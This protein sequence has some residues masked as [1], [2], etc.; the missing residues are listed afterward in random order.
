MASA[1]FYPPQRVAAALN[2]YRDN[3]DSAAL[4][5]DASWSALPD[6]GWREALSRASSA[7]RRACSQAL[8]RAAGVREPPFGAFATPAVLGTGGA[9]VQPAPGGPKPNL[10]LLDALPVG[11]ALAVLRMRS[12]S[13]RRVEVRRLIDKQTRSRLADWT[14]VHPD[15]IAQDAHAA[16]APDV[17]HLAMKTGLPPLARLDATAMAVEGWLLF[18]R[19]AGGAAEAGDSANPADR[20]RPSLTRLALPRAFAPPAS[21]PAASGLDAAGSIRLFA[22]MPDLLPEVAWL[23][24]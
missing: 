9:G 5:A 16:D 24:G 11:Q 6:N 20:R 4:W 14:G 1:Q 8:A 23:F 3:L 18:V 19:D 10:A 15:A 13:F 21:L 7:A 17:A 12:L 22:R 2:G